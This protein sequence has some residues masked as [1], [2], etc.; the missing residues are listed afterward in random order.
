MEAQVCVA[1][2]I[3]KSKQ[4]HVRLA[5]IVKTIIET[6]IFNM[7]TVFGNNNTYI[8]T[9]RNSV[10]KHT[11]ARNVKDMQFR[12]FGFLYLVL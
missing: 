10:Y 1:L 7:L 4:I 2:I 6:C 3:Q 5:Y 12:T 8:D 9:K 11:T